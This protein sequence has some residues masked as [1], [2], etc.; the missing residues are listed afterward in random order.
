[1]SCASVSELSLDTLICANYWTPPYLLHPPTM[2]KSAASAQT[3]LTAVGIDLMVKA[4]QQ[5]CSTELADN[6]SALSCISLP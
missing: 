6:T 2:L 3:L 4:S 5:N 1:M